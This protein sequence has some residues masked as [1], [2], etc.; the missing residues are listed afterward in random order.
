MEGNFCSDHSRQRLANRI[1]AAP[2]AVQLRKLPRMSTTPRVSLRYKA[3]E[4]SGDALREI[5]FVIGVLGRFSGAG[6]P[7]ATLWE[8]SF[9]SIDAESF[10]AVRGSMEPHP[11][12]T[13]PGER[14]DALES[15]WRSLQFLLSRVKPDPLLKIK[16]MDVDKEE[17]AKDLCNAPHPAQSLL[18][19]QFDLAQ[20]VDGEPFGLLIGNYSFSAEPADVRLLNAIGGFAA[21]WLA[22]FIADAGPAMF[23]VE[24]F[25]TL[26]DFR[27]LDRIF[28]DER[29]SQW[30]S[31]R[32]SEGSR[33]VYLTLPR[34]L[35]REQEQ[36]QGE[37]LLWGPA[38]F[39][40]GLCVANAFSKYGWCAAFR[41][42]EGGGL[43]E[44]VPTTSVTEFGKEIRVGVEVVLP[45]RE[46]EFSSLGFIQLI[47]DV[48]GARSLFFSASSCHK[49]EVY[50]SADANAASRLSNQLQ[51]VLTGC[52]FLHYL[53]AVIASAGLVG[54]QEC[55]NILNSWIA[56]YCLTDDD[57]SLEEQAGRPLREARIEVSEAPER[58]GVYR[59]VAHLRPRFQL[60]DIPFPL[61]FEMERVVAPRS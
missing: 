26:G 1:L 33:F 16:L 56:Q 53:G 37:G 27:R 46:M 22:P 35:V 55:E 23:G 59:V 45:E 52:R 39:A 43:I 12:S 32:K 8:R 9:I 4:G 6:A 13:A 25:K 38:A 42:V 21:C 3:A 40:L 2:D 50:L 15:A 17:L 41:G 34:M 54:R 49:I 44:N 28:E 18:S 24:D 5:P 47:P 7:R 11:D 31:F 19:R 14:I 36:E 61:R 58:P 20:T 30:R 60:D 48:R 29:Y 57:A 51:Y 10:D